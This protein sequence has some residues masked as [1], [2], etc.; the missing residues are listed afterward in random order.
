VT[1]P[2]AAAQRAASV[3][4]TRAPSP[5]VQAKR[6][7]LRV[8]DARQPRRGRLLRFV[9]A[10][11]VVGSL[12][13]VV[14]GHSILAQ[15]QVRLTSAQA[16][17]SSEQAI[18]RQLLAAVAEA[19]NPAQIIAEAKKLNL[20]T[21]SSITQLPAVPLTTPVGQATTAPT[22]APTSTASSTAAAGP[23]ATAGR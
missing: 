3:R 2:P 7:S 9:A 13:A 21:P 15:G 8:L 6:P 22:T 23:S 11:L 18:H 14:V 1:P 19:E 4:A 20:V 17:M 12:L 10:S 16:Q 5:R